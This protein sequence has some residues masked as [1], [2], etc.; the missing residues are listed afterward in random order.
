MI[1]SKYHLF[2]DSLKSLLIFTTLFS[3]CLFITSLD[4]NKA[5]SLF[6][7]SANSDTFLI[8]DNPSFGYKIKYPQ[9][10]QKE[11]HLDNF[12]TFSAQREDSSQSTYPAAIGIK[13]QIINS[14]EISLLSI[15][16]QHS[17]E[18]VKLPDFKLL[19]SQS[20]L[21]SNKIKAQKIVFTATDDENIKR[22]SFQI[23]T[24]YQNKA[25]LIT[26]KALVERYDSYLKTANEMI[27]SFEIY[28]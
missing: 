18:L 7:F 22:K 16:K 12:I 10:W 26:Y 17:K 8:Y 11:T 14:S 9:Q 28:K 23:L 24:E 1:K 6:D 4:N 20:I 27:N 5:Y 3:V 15:I 25:F 19:D 21:L 13:S 2:S